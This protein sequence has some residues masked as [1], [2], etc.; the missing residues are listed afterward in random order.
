M[1]RIRLDKNLEKSLTPNS[2]IMSNSANEYQSRT[3]QEARDIL[4]ISSI[5]K[6]NGAPT[7]NPANL[8]R[9]NLWIDTSKPTEVISHWWNPQA[10]LVNH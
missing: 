1:T 6:G 2:V 4:K 3:E 7:V 8:T 9:V 10:L 5:E